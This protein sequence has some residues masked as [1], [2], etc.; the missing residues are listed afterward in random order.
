MEHTDS[1]VGVTAVSGGGGVAGL[2]CCTLY[3]SS[4]EGV[5]MSGQVHWR[6]DLRQVSID[7]EQWVLLQQVGWATDPD[8]G[9]A[10]TACR[11]DHV[12][13]IRLAVVV[14]R[15]ESDDGR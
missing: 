12:P 5:A 14:V 15:P 6:N 11:A 2:A 3:G 10:W 4:T 8:G 7:A 1:A 13:P 9:E